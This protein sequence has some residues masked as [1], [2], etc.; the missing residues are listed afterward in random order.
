MKILNTRDQE[1]Q[2][3]KCLIG[4]PSGAGKTTL[5]GTI[6]GKTLVISAES[7]LMSVAHK[8]LDYIDLS[9]DDAG[10]VLTDPAMRIKRLEEIFKYLHLGCPGEDGK[11]TWR[12][13]NVFLDSLTE[14]SEVLVQK[15]QKEFPDRKDTFPMWGEYGKAMR[16]IVKNFRD[17][18]YNVYMSAITEFDKDDNNKRFLSFCVSGSISNKLPQYFDEVFVLHVNAEGVRSLI[19]RATDTLIHCKD[20]SGR[21]A[22][23]EPADLGAIARKI[24][25]LP[26]EEGKK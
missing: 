22:P 4:G 19:T 18:P 6:D 25:V 13:K 5:S 24:L 1:H 17:L 12:Y 7:G 9:R 21:L 20:R 16:A 10:N 14:V 15:Y 2:K 11:A 8:E 26:K 23:Q 3:I